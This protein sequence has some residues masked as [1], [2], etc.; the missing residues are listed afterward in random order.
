MNE[1]EYTIKIIIIIRM[2]KLYIIWWI[3]YNETDDKKNNDDKENINKSLKKYMKVYEKKK[4]IQWSDL[5][6]IF[7]NQREK[8]IWNYTLLFFFFII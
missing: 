4:I 6:K 3:I 7:L 5:K 1:N 8:N 2:M